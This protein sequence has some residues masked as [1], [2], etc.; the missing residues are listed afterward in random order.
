MSK[1]DQAMRYYEALLEELD[2]LGL[3]PE[4]SELYKFTH[5]TIEKAQKLTETLPAHLLEMIK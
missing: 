3:D 5:S 1:K 4:K 2:S